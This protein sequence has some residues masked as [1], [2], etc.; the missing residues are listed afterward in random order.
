MQFAFQIKGRQVGI[1]LDSFPSMLLF[2]LVAGAAIG[3]CF[4]AIGI[5][6]LLLAALC[7][8][9]GGTLLGLG[10]A[11]IALVLALC[12]A[13]FVLWLIFI[14]LKRLVKE[15]SRFFP[16]AVHQ[17]PTP[18]PSSPSTP[19]EQHDTNNSGSSATTSPSDQHDNNERDT[20]AHGNN[21]A[22]PE[23]TIPAAAVPA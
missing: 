5:A 22:F 2:V 23:E 7:I 19:G 8:V 17:K 15:A 4:I 9:L 10:I 13:G 14:G 3:A 11:F 18:P 1:K 20:T 21:A 16:I 6:V 12:A